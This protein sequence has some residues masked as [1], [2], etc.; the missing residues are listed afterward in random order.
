MSSTTRER[1]V[2]EAMRLFS[3]HGYKATTIAR[4]EAASGLTPGAG[5]VYHHFQS[6]E[7][8][9][10]AGIDR[11]LK[12]LRGLGAVRQVFTSLGDL[13]AE[14]TLIAR[15]IL[16][17]L[18]EEAQLI[19]LLA[20]DARDGPAGLS[21]AAQRLTDASLAGFSSWIAERAD[22]PLTAGEASALAGAGL[23]SLLSSRLLRDVL[24]VTPAVDDAAFVDAWVHM[25]RRA[26]TA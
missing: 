16:A 18:D 8:V 9:L 7:A 12:R 26:L 21:T 14:L 17:E 6:K 22:P 19:R 25:M 10:D 13:R 24:G 5:G 3:D 15:Y 1:I 23:G 11:Q 4:I 2:D 20:F